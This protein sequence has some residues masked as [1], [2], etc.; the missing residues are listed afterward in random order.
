MRKNCVSFEDWAESQYQEFKSVWQRSKN[1][2]H[3]WVDTATA[4]FVK[5]LS[6]RSGKTGSAAVSKNHSRD[7]AFGLAWAN[8]KG[9]EIPEFPAPVLALKTAK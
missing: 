8:Y 4:H 6:L 7:V 2:E 1:L 3:Q 5:V 9:E